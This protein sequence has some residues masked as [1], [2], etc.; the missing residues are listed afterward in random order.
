ME[1]ISSMLT[2]ALELHRAGNLREAEHLYRL[3]LQ[4]EQRNANAL[5]LLGLLAHQVGQHQYALEYIRQAVA[6]DPNEPVF[7]SNLGLVHQSQNQLEEAAACYRRALALSPGY[8]EAHNNLGSVLRAQGRLDEAVLCFQEALRLRP[9]FLEARANLR[10]ALKEQSNRDEALF[11][12]GCLLV[13]RGELDE[14]IAC[15]RQVLE[16]RFQPAI[17]AYNLGYALF[18]RGQW[19][20]A[21]T[22]YRQALAHKPDLVE[23]HHGLGIALR[24]LGRLNEAVLCYQEALRLRPDYPE[25][26]TDLGIALQEQGKLDEALACYRQ[27]LASKPDYAGGYNNVANI[28]KDMGLLDDALAAYRRA[29]DLRPDVS[30]AHSN[31]IYAMHFHPDS[32][33]RLLAEECERWYQRHALPLASTIRPHA[34]DADPDRPL[35][36]GYLSPDFRSHAVGLMLMPLLESHDRHVVKSYCYSTVLAPDDITALLRRRADEWREAADL[37]DG[38]LADLIRADGIDILVDLTAHMS[39]NLLLLFARKPAPVQVTYLAYC[40]TTGLR[41]IDYRLTDPYLDPPG[42][43]TPFYV[44]ESVWLPETY[45]CYQHFFQAPVGSLPALARGQVT[46]GCLNNFCKVTTPVLAAWRDLLGSVPGSRLLL[47]A[48]TGSHRGRVHRFFAAGGVEPDRVEFVGYMP[49]ANYCL[50]Y[51]QIDIGLDPFPYNGGATT[52]DALWMGVPVVSLAGT[53]AVSRAGLS[54]LTN[55]GLA[56]LV[57][58][59]PAEYVSIAARLAGDLPRLAALR[60]GLRERMQASPLTDAPRFARNVEAA[61]RD[62]WRRW[63]AH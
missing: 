6:L 28:L 18:R 1:N 58:R 22:A 32:G 54:I 7:C 44:E 39:E 29:V 35:R 25:A 42:E 46:F 17:T 40:S 31:L 38:R 56:E 5:N 36:V 15:Y 48:N 43:P 60:A 12:R 11:N 52:C 27:L 23:A 55:V 49:F 37:T 9:D 59:T 47:H 13:S 62:M 3:V 30:A 20:E 10:I 24:A 8:A 50:L 26:R 4:S 21:E 63:C 34:N 61:Y 51:Q 19:K 57:A 33:P 14:A 53:N 16:R 2:R 41:A 45:W